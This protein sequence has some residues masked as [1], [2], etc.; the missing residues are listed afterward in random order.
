MRRLIRDASHELRTPLLLCVVVIA[1]GSACGLPPS[2]ICQQYLECQ[3]HHDEVLDR[4]PAS[5]TNIYRADGTCWENDDLAERCDEVCEE[6]V[7]ALRE[8]LVDRSQNLGPC[9]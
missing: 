8:R 2:E 6:R 4:P 1:L 3:D 7:L 5:D 9:E